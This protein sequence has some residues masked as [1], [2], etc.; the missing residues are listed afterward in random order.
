MRT[1]FA[2][3]DITLI[4]QTVMF[5]AIRDDRAQSRW[6]MGINED[7]RR[8]ASPC[9]NAISTRTLNSGSV[10]KLRESRLDL[11]SVVCCSEVELP[12]PLNSNP[13]P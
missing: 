7:L 3:F 8:K 2:D 10:V 6:R 13:K 4:P 5:N 1:Q 11:R 9:L 12:F